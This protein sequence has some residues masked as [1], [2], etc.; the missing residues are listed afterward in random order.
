MKRENDGNT[1][2][3]IT[4]F[5]KLI[6]CIHLGFWRRCAENYSIFHR[7]TL[8]SPSVLSTSFQN[9]LL[10]GN[11]IIIIHEHGS[12]LRLCMS[13][14]KNFRILHLH[15][16]VTEMISSLLVSDITFRL[17]TKFSFPQSILSL[18]R[19][20]LCYTQSILLLPLVR[21]IPLLHCG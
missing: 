15:I 14:C 4:A 2:E 9:R 10:K 18:W 20:Q 19:S 12:I 6:L 1:L 8:R 17:C 11:M 16:V 3:S 5:T 7:L 13:Q 21:L